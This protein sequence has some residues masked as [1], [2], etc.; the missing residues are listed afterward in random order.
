MQFIQTKIQVQGNEASLRCYIPD[1]C[2]A[3]AY[4]DHRP[5]VV[6]FPG[7]GYHFTYSG[8]AEPIALKFVADGA[9]AFVLDYSCAPV[10]FPIPQLQ[11]FAAIKFVRENAEKFGIDEN[12]IATLGFSAG[13]HLCST[14]G[15]LWNKFDEYFTQAGMADVE[16]KVYRPDKMILCYPV[17]C[18]PNNP[19]A[20]Q[21]SFENL[22]G[23]RCKD[24]S[25]LQLLSTEKQVDEQTPPTFIWHTSEDS[26]VPCVNSYRFA[27]ALAERKIPCE[28]H[29][30]LHGNHGLC[31]GTSV[32]GAYEFTAPHESS[33]WIDKAIRFLFAKI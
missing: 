25:L 1:A 13:G 2:G 28:V 7:G 27:L 8:E 10:R 14:T 30:F 3:T 18:A 26:G 31:L 4:P 5:A 11:A 19:F 33:E 21:G 29:V 12:N 17:I 9:C 32:T 15:T 20:H 16:S 24:L 23:E 6:V 22:L